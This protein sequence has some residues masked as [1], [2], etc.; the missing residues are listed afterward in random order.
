MMKKLLAGALSAV[1]MLGAA[2]VLPADMGIGETVTAA[3]A[4][5]AEP[6]IYTKTWGYTLDGDEAE[7]AEYLGSKS[8]TSLSVPEKIGGKTVTSISRT[9]LKGMTKLKKL[10]LPSG[11]DEDFSSDCVA[12]CPALTDIT[13]SADNPNM[14]SSDG[15][16]YFTSLD[17]KQAMIVVIPP[18]RESITIPSFD[19]L[20]W[21]DSS[22]ST[23]GADA[24]AVRLR[25]IK[26]A[27]EMRD[28]WTY[29]GVLYYHNEDGID[30]VMSIPKAK[31]TLYIP[32]RVTVFSGGLYET[33]L[34]NRCVKTIYGVK[35]SG[36]EKFAKDN[37]IK[38]VA[39]KDLYYCKATIPYA[40][41]TYRGR[42]IKPTVTVKDST[43]KKLVKGTDYTVTYSNNTDVGT[44]TITVN[45]KGDYF[46]TLTKTFKVKPLDLSTSYAKV[47]I[48]YASYTCSGS[49]IKPAVTV[50]FKDGDVIPASQYTLSYSDNT[51]VGTA[52]ITVKGKGGNVTGSFKKTF[53]VKP[54][55]NAINSITSTAGAFKISW[56]KATPGATGYQVLYSTDKSFAKNVHSYTSTN[57]S[58]LS[59][60]FS[61]VPK[62]GETW[63][64]KVRSF[65]TKDGKATSTRYGNY[66]AVRSIK[67]R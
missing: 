52:A 1:L 59:E 48:P 51:K 18:A 4:D 44:A 2:A 43:G 16:L 64:V 67:V 22:P 56:N 24:F 38:F 58:D 49:A 20:M 23:S 37:G 13:V 6:I 57:L 39:K 53:V 46:G 7:L 9:A 11:I 28:L 50:K 45:G 31:T 8:V 17:R 36:A 27:G 62:S 21:L 26:L 55:K 40:S 66:S 60:N 33:I 61:K 15:V 12:E 14:Y 32:G 47:T 41:Y 63:Y 5:I 19:Y 10:H 30:G 65:V 42:G 34:S 54:A 35:G 29:D 3:A 25:E